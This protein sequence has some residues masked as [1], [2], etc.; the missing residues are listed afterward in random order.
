MLML[1]Q[2]QMQTDNDAQGLATLDKLVAATSTTNPDVHAIRGNA[3]YRL[4]RYPA[5]ITALNR[6]STPP[7]PTPTRSVSSS[8]WRQSSTGTRP[9]SALPPQSPTRRRT[10][11]NNSSS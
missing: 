11:T 8:R 3:L 9:A 10:P 2:L 1:G 7:A 6:R 5:A 4:E